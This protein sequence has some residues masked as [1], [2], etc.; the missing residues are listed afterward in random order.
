MG[1]QDLDGDLLLEH[2]VLGEVD[3]PVAPATEQPEELALPD[4]GSDPVLRPMG[5]RG[6]GWNIAARGVGR[7][8]GHGASPEY[9]GHPSTGFNS[10]ITQMG[11]AGTRV[12][13][14]P[15]GGRS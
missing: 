15:R 3:L 10:K 1:Q 6:G 7:R 13:L 9:A 4:G 8:H 12:T 14:L 2:G 5:N 11:N